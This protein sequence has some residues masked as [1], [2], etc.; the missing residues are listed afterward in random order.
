MAVHVGR[1]G[2]ISRVER[3]DRSDPRRWAAL[4]VLCT[5]LLVVMLD[6]TILNVALPTLVRDLGATS[7]Q[8][9]W[10]VDAYALTFGGLMLV[11]GS[12]ADRIG[13]KRV[14]IAGLLTFAAG[15]AACAFSR[16]VE[17][18]IAARA[19]MGVGAALIMPATLSI[20]TDMFRDAEERQ[21]AFGAWAGTSGLGL[22]IGP[23][24]GGL[25]LAHFAWGSVFLVNLPIVAIGLA[26][27]IPL[28]PESRNATKPRLDPAGAALCTSGLG[29]ILW[30]IIEAPGRGWTSPMVVTVGAFGIALLGTFIA[31]ERRTDHPMLNLR[32]FRERRFSVATSMG[33]LTNFAM[34]GAM[35]MLTQFLQF[36][37]GFT[38]LEA[39]VRILPAAGVLAVTAPL[40]SVIV[41][42]VGSK[43]TI[44]AGLLFAATGMWLLSGA[45]TAS[46]YS[47]VIVGMIL[48][49]AGSGLVMPSV[50]GSVMGTLPRG[51]TGVGSGT[52]GTSIQVGGALGVAVIGSLLSTRYQDRITASLA[53][54]HVPHSLMDTILGSIG[55]ALG[56]AGQAGGAIGAA[57]TRMA[58]DAFVSGMD[59]GLMV[60]AGVVLAGAAITLAALPGRP[61]VTQPL[62]TSDPEAR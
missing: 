47:D 9:Q 24:A 11:G 44:A 23:L 38:P 30:A 56:V 60:G 58:D 40:S 49:G 6:N 17:P 39:G 61:A 37:L 52:N 14:F 51:D 8:L 36:D 18:L 62:P 46:T 42:A 5:S 34:F 25:L 10:I 57:L 15:S 33:G 48:L 29:V 55:G 12:L 20:I 16:S 26:C 22:A 53:P 32:F 3:P 28:V 59:L 19:F 4:F 35:F 41:R 50:T 7:T 21:R 54:Y 27:A 45:T 43:L 13:R 31:W 1:V 2:P